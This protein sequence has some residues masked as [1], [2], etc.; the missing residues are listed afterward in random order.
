M[1]SVERI[2]GQIENSPLIDL[3]KVVGEEMKNNLFSVDDDGHE[4]I[5]RG[6][7]LYLQVDDEEVLIDAG[8]P[9]NLVE[10]MRLAAIYGTP[11]LNVNV[12]LFDEGKVVKTYSFPF[13]VNEVARALERAIDNLQKLAEE[14]SDDYS[15]SP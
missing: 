9:H 11:F 14:P 6:V 15:P 8:Y 4:Q 10:I 1:E 12:K 7:L 2:K 3:F 5:E 13:T